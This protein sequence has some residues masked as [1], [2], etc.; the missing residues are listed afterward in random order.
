MQMRTV[1]NYSACWRSKEV[2]V[3][4]SGF[5]HLTFRQNRVV[6]VSSVIAKMFNPSKC[7]T[8]TIQLPVNDSL[9][10]QCLLLFIASYLLFI[11]YS[12]LWFNSVL[13]FVA[14]LLFDSIL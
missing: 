7:W 12:V 2:L 8:V 1:M 4:T 10:N 9:F 6:I 3:S 11:L 5:K 13:L 14:V